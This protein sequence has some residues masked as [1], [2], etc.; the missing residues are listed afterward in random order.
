MKKY[1]LI[2]PFAILFSIITFASGVFAVNCSC[3]FDF[4][5]YNEPRCSAKATLELIEG[6]QYN[7]NDLFDQLAEEANNS[8]CIEKYKNEEFPGLLESDRSFLIDACGSESSNPFRLEVTRTLPAPRDQTIKSMTMACLVSE[9]V[10]DPLG[11]PNVPAPPSSNPSTAGLNTQAD[12]PLENISL[13]NPIGETSVNRILGRLV[14]YLGIGVLGALELVVFAYAGFKILTA[15]GNFQDV[16]QG[17]AAIVAGIGGLL[18]VF[19]TYGIL[20]MLFG[21]IF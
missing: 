4:F 8:D 5:A 21:S 1:F 12:K 16:R 19:A 14:R 3:E 10:Q 15:R 6:S 2:I 13:P 17:V 9:Q 11:S 20:N 7:I 18:L